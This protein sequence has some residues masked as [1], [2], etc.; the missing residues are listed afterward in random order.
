MN[1]TFAAEFAA[2]ATFWA[3]WLFIGSVSCF[4]PW[5]RHHLGWTIVGFDAAIGLVLVPTMIHY[6]FPHMVPGV[7]LS[8]VAVVSLASVPPLLVWRA[9]VIWQYQ[10]RGRLGGTS[11][12]ADGRLGYAREPAPEGL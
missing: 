12:I 5:W 7:W 1:I 2:R 3:C 6:W 4:W 8:W 9:M 10:R 11:D